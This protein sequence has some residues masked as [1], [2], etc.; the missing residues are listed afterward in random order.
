M[1]ERDERR[2]GDV[3]DSLWMPTQRPKHLKVTTRQRLRVPFL[4]QE[5]IRLD[6]ALILPGRRDEAGRQ[7][8]LMYLQANKVW[9][10]YL[11]EFSETLEELR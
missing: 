4:R 10:T 5:G 11:V 1:R 6:R 2:G 8:S 9:E 3:L 7:I